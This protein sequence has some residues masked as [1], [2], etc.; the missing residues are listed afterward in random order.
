MCG[1]DRLQTLDRHQ[2]NYLPAQDYNESINVPTY[3]RNE[4]LWILFEKILQTKNPAEFSI[5][6]CKSCGL[7]FSNPRM[8]AEEIQIKYQTLDELA[9]VRK[10]PQNRPPLK[11]DIRAK[12]IYSLLAKLQKDSSKSLKILDYG[13]GQGYNLAS[14][15]KAGHSC[16]VVDYLKRELPPGIE[17][18]GRKLNDSQHNGFFDVILFCHTL[19]HVIDPQQ[20]VKD[21][22]AYLTAGGL[23]YVEVPLGSFDEWRKLDEPLT[24]INFF[25]EES[26]FKCL[27]N[28]GLDIVHLSTSRQWVTQS[29]NWC[30]NIVGSNRKGNTI[31]KYRTTVE[32]MNPPRSIDHPAYYLKQSVKKFKRLTK[33]VIS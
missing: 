8:T 10:R 4:K 3:Y 24:H 15:V 28:A 21:L 29:D 20:I 25:S 14:F 17:Y 9:T 27:S 1:C 2:F 23:L 5:E 16:H 19:E 30:V 31:T 7:I 33:S 6:L 22:S 18:L 12:R 26:A 32:Q 11:T 13:G